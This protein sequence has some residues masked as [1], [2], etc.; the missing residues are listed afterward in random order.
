MTDDQGQL[1]SAAKQMMSLLASEPSVLPV[2]GPPGSG[3]TFTG[4]RMIVELISQGYRVGVA[5]VSHKVISNLLSEVMQG[6]PT[7]QRSGSSGT[8]TRCDRWM[9]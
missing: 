1:T 3:K 2:Q 6:C 8:E 9:Y 5:A 7:E 4:A